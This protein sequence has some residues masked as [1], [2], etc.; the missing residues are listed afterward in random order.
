V[1]DI[2][3]VAAEVVDGSIAVHRALGPGLLESAYQ[4]CLAHELRMRS[5][6]V[7]CEVPLPVHYRGLDVETGFRIDMVVEDLVLVENKAVQSI[8][9]IH[10]AQILTYLKLSGRKL[11]FLINWNVPMIKQGIRRFA[12]RL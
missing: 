5:L 8:L 4:A 10:E 3:R 11:G 9:P 1:V 2:E 6:H 7:E 12:N